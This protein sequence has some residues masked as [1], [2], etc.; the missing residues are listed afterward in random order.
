MPI[1]LSAQGQKTNK[2]YRVKKKQQ[3]G[4]SADWVRS[5]LQWGGWNYGDRSQATRST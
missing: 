2:K 5:S 4:T 3:G 1:V